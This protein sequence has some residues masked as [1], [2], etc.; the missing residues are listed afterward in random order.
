MCCVVLCCVVLQV[1]P[2]EDFKEIVGVSDTFVPAA[3]VWV[4]EYPY[5]EKASKNIALR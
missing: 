2:D 5:L 4:G 3:N 1:S